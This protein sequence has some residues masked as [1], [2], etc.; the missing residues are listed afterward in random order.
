MAFQHQELWTRLSE[1]KRLWLYAQSVFS[2]K[3]ALS[4]LLME[5]ESKSRWLEL[6]ARE[7]IERATRAEAERDATHHKVVM[8]RL[9]INAASNAWH[10]WN[11]N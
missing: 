2:N 8:A 9:E 11:L 5:A 7:A 6:E 3:K 10:R 1:A 4:A